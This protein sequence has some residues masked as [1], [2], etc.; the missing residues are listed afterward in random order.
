MLRH[1]N[2][3]VCSLGLGLSSY[4]FAQAVSKPV[5]IIE[6]SKSVTTVQ[7]AAID[8]E[9]FEFGPYLG[10]MSTEDFNTNPVTGVSLTYHINSK[11]LSQITYG[12]STVSQAAFEK[13]NNGNFLAKDDYKFKY[14]NFLAGYN[15]LDGRSF[16]GKNYKFN[17]A[18]YVL[19][20]LSEVSFANNSNPGVILGVSY[21]VVITDWI[22]A[23]V[24]LRNTMVDREFLDEKKKTNNTEMLMGIN[25][26]F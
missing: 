5:K 19:G 21:R 17:S 6:P 8:T 12:S 2:I 24:D 15:L 14:L 20:G 1:I 13:L 25:L 9:H 16:F 7:A 26:L 18:I 22:T 23:N 4:S 10:L 11:F 3:L